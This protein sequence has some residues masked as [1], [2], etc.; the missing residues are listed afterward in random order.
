MGL[1]AE[2]ICPAEYSSAS[3][4][5]KCCENKHVGFILLIRSCLLN[6]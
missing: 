2:R 6:L 1:E 3:T 4:Q 5:A